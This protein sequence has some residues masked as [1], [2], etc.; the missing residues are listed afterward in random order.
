MSSID[1]LTTKIIEDSENK[2]KNIIDEAKAEEKKLIDTKVNE[3]KAQKKAMLQKAE[4]EA[5]IRRERVISNAELQVRNMKLEAKQKVLDKTFTEALEKLS[6]ISQEKML[7]FI[8]N[9]ILS[10]EL[11]SDVEIVLGKSSQGVTE[12]F[13]S[14]LNKSL[15]MAGKIARV[16]LSPQRRDIKGGFILSRNGVEINYSFEALVKNARSELESEVA[17]TL[18]N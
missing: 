6:N 10:A 14:D 12:E 15:Q 1:R 13:I 4:D 2:A 16:K 9:N 7:Q 11:T 18:F 8:R 3:A 17:S 5:K